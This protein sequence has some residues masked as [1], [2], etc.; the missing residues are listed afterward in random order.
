MKCPTGGSNKL[1]VQQKVIVNL[2]LGGKVYYQVLVPQSGAKLYG[3][4]CAGR[5]AQTAC[6]QGVDPITRCRA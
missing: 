4:I 3:A 2:I 6:H 5:G 1:H